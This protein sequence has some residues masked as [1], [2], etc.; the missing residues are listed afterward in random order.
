MGKDIFKEFDGYEQI[1]AEREVVRKYGLDYSPDKDDSEQYIRRL[2][3]QRTGASGFRYHHRDTF[4]EDFP[5]GKSKT[6]PSR[7]FWRANTW[8]YFWISE[9][10]GR[11]VRTAFP[12]P[13]IKPDTT[14]LPS[15]GWQTVWFPTIFMRRLKR[16]IIF[17]ARGRKAIFT[18]T[19]CSTIAPWSAWPA[20]A[21]LLLL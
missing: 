21:G 6:T 17:K 18:I 13:P 7:P 16:G 12:P 19:P 3:P 10:S 4:Y 15:G 2:H 8:H 20:G 9:E 5:A 1:V 14:I 11:D